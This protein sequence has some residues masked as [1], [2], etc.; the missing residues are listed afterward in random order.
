MPNAKQ[1]VFVHWHFSY[2]K[3]IKFVF[4][5]FFFFCFVFLIRIKKKNLH[6]KISETHNDD[7]NFYCIY[8]I[9]HLYNINVGF[10]GVSFISAC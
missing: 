4:F 2:I 8:R 3:L 9:P 7:D 5:F 10:E 6:S 1:M